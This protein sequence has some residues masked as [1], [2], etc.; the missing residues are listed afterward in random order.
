MHRTASLPL[1]GG[2]L[3]LAALLAVLLAGCAA[4]GPV[5]GPGTTS[6]PTPAATTLPAQWAGAGAVSHLTAADPAATR[7]WWQGFDDPLLPTLIDQA[8]AHNLDLASAR[9][10]LARARALRELTAA[11]Q[12]P[13]IGLGAGAG[14]SRSG[15]RSGDSLRVGLDASWE[16]DLFGAHA[17][18]LTAADADVE[19]AAAMLQATRLAI[20]AETGLAYLQ[21]QGARAQQ[22]AAETSLASQ[23]QTR[24][25]VELRERSGLAG[26]LEVEQAGSAVLQLQARLAALQHAQTQALHALAVLTGTNASETPPWLAA[27]RARAAD[28]VARAPALPALPQPAALLQRRPDLQAAEHRIESQLATLS[29]REAERRPSLR[30]S[31]NLGLQAATLSALGGSGALVAGLTAAINWPLLDGGAGKA[32][33]EAQQTA[34]DAARIDW[35]A[36]VL[37]ASRDVE[38]ALS[39]LATAREREATLQRAS[40]TAGEALRLARIGHEA[41]LSD[42]LNLLDA[43]RSALSAADALATARTDLASSHIRLYKAL[44]GG[45]HDPDPD[46]RS[47]R[48]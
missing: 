10:K 34:L 20:A 30:I 14:R 28:A 21:W 32:R 13:Q 43:E 47:P 8:L 7:D 17:A 35:Q 5:S 3:A 18:A 12:E 33:V 39:A 27:A 41:G 4:L 46:A 26:G 11:T 16:A 6:S 45:W 38:D 19:D 42:F 29:L 40:V 31:G 1:A 22:A 25:L 15:G 37:A 36:A 9:S 44:G 48:P 24:A 23:Q 2:T